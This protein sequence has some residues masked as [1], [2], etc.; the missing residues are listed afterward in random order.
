MKTT[1]YASITLLAAIL[2]S[3]CAIST[4][5]RG[6]GYDHDRGITLADAG[7]RVIVALTHATLS[8]RRRNFDDDVDAVAASLAATDGL[9]AYSLRKELLGNQAWTMTVWRDQAALAAFVAS[10]AHQR[11]IRRSAGELSAVRFRRFEI[12]R[13]AL[14]ISWDTA[15]ARLEESAAADTY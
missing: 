4:P 6:P 9:I 12:E 10:S 15:L 14:P 11:A 5:F 1:V 3:G 13:S 7:D 8:E 2:S